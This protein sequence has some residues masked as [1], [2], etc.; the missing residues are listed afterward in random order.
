MSDAD[1]LEETLHTAVDY[2]L[3]SDEVRDDIKRL[4]ATGR[5][6]NVS[7]EIDEFGDGVAIKF[8]FEERPVIEKIVLKGN[9]EII[10]T[11]LLELMMLKENDVYREIGR[12][13]V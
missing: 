12:A 10:E 2:P 8:I 7:V 6:K 4:F 5:F 9:D 13:H 11:D 3:K 1:D